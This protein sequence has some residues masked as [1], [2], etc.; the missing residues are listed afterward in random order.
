VT[1][2]LETKDEQGIYW[3]WCY[4]RKRCHNERHPKFHRYGGRGITI[5]NDWNDFAAF[6]RDMSPTYQAGLTLDR[7]DNDGNYE[8]SNCRWL[9]KAEQPKNQTNWPH[10]YLN[11][12]SWQRLHSPA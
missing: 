1:R 9:S 7:I 11:S 2:K 4:M 12:P 8:P 5:C 6:Y 3:S 10:P